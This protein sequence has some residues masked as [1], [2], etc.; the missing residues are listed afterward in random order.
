MEQFAPKCSAGQKFGLVAGMQKPLRI[1]KI[2]YATLD[3]LQENGDEAQ[4][5]GYLVTVNLNPEEFAGTGSVTPLM[6]AA[7]C[8]ASRGSEDATFRRCRTS[9]QPRD[10][11]RRP[12]CCD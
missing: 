6:R 10:W 8:R 11:C 1:P 4:Q 12:L 3:V 2:V 7:E 5:N 9:R